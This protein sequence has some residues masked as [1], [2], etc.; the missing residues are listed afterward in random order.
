MLHSQN[1]QLRPL[2]AVVLV[3]RGVGCP[4]VD[5]HPAVPIPAARAAR[6]SRGG[7]PSPRPVGRAQL[8]CSPQYRARCTR[9]A[10]AHA[11]ILLVCAPA[12]CWL[13]R[14]YAARESLPGTAPA[15]SSH[16]AAVGPLT[17]LLRSYRRQRLPSA[18]TCGPSDLQESRTSR[19]TSVG[20]SARSGT[21]TK[22]DRSASPSHLPA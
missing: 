1:P 9:A 12:P 11:L 17:T 3:E 19:A 16:H 15:S 6:T 2:V 14:G 10:P 4:D 8:P 18:S 13:L 21:A 22:V 7:A 5:P 20:R